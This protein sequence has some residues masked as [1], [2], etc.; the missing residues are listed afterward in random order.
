MDVEH[1]VRV[2][3]VVETENERD[4]QEI[5]LRDAL[6]ALARQTY[7]RVLTEFIVVDSGDIPGLARVVAE[8]LPDARIVDGAGLTE[9]QMKNLGAREATGEIVA[10]CDGD[11]AP[12]PEWIEEVARSLGQASPSV[13]GVQGR[14]VLRPGLFSRQISVLLYGLRTDASARVSRRIVSDNC[15][16]RR[17]FFLQGGFEQD[18]LPTTPET[19]LSTRLARRALTMIVN[20]AMRSVHDYPRTSGLHGLTAMLGFFLRRA[21]SNGYCMTRVRFLMSGLRAGWVRWLGPAG[22][23]VLVA[24]KIVADLGQIVQ[25]DQHLQL[26]WLDWIPFSPFYLAYYAG[27]LV[28]GYAALLKVPAPRF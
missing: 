4:A 17:D 28:G 9:Y 16:F 27:H 3:V 10:F 25:N 6:D 8:H 18:Q 24:G 5:R 7:P 21:Y 26:T 23:P 14:T 12:Q 2:T 15:A 19:V 11:C 22:P 1:R 20:N 13:V